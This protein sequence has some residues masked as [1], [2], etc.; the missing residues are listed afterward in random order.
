MLSKRS[1]SQPLPGNSQD[2]TGTVYPPPKAL[3]IAASDAGSYDL[4]ELNDD[5]SLFGD[6]EYKMD[7]VTSLLHLH[8]QSA[9]DRGREGGAGVPLFNSGRPWSL[10]QPEEPIRRYGQ[11][12]ASW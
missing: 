8:R 1:Y 5:E 3:S 2:P 9:K 12:R 11:H 10:E 4:P 7:E 6:V